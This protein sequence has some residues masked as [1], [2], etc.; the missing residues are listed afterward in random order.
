[1][2]STVKKIMVVFTV[3]CMLFA[4]LPVQAASPVISK[5]A[6]TLTIGKSTTL[7]VKNAKGKIKWKSSNSKIASVSKRGKVTGKKTGK[8]KITAIVNKRHYRCIVTVKATRKV[9]KVTN[10]K[11][12]KKNITLKAGKAYTLKASVSPSKASNKALAWK[13]SN[14]S[15][16]SVNSKGV[17]SAKKAGTVTITATAKDGSKKKASCKVTVKK[18][19]KSASDK[20]VSKIIVS[21]KKS[22]NINGTLQLNVSVQ[23]SGL[24]KT[25][26]WKSDN[27]KIATVSSTGLVK[28]VSAGT[29]KITVTTNDK[30]KDSIS[31]YITV[32]QPQN[33][34]TP[35]PVQKTI[36]GIEAVCGITEAS[37]IDD[38]KNH[39]T[40]YENY[41]DGTKAEVKGYS[42]KA[43]STPDSYKCTVTKTGTNFSTVIN[44]KKKGTSSSEKTLTGITAECT[45]KE[46]SSFDELIDNLVV[47]AHYSDGSTAEL[48]SYRVTSSVGGADGYGANI[49][50]MDGKFKTSVSAKTKISSVT[51]EN[52][53]ASCK[54]SEVESGYT[55]KTSD[56]DVKGVYSDGSKKNIGFKVDISYSNGAY[57]AII[58]AEN[59]SVTL[60]IPVKKS[61]TPEV[62]GMT[63]SLNPSYVYVGEN[64]ANGQLKVT[65]KYSDGSQ[66]EVTDY[67]CDFKPQSSAG[68][69]TFNVTWGT[70]KKAISIT[71]KEKTAP[72]PT[73]TGLDAKYNSSYVYAGDPFDASKIILTGTY[74]DG[75]TKQITD[76]TYDFTPATDHLGK[77]TLI[78]HYAG[79][80]MTIRITSIV[81]TEPKSVEFKFMNVP[82][83]VGENIDKSNI[84][85]TATDYAGTV[86]NP[87]DFTID[88]SPKTEAGTYPFTV[89]YKGFSETFNVTVK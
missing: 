89:S 83:G 46:V 52:I 65:A 57:K 74:S 43:E 48:K 30:W 26:T 73:L 37:S 33:T 64:L 67:A 56:F 66:K 14:K 50:T 19:S 9:T 61:S 5:K 18:A 12:N 24:S 25:F 77:A 22:V 62:T 55:F 82:I 59:H 29:V 39:M 54:Y 78:I 75:S 69:Y 85:I 42:V 49:E 86:T 34:P 47:T 88:F 87:T 44:V 20:R 72:T 81:K 21:S 16:A 84:T 51:L 15:I 23:P 7:K 79:Q 35:E 53:E 80:N 10:V 40:V 11:L 1:M 27:T 13:S 32:N 4:S 38:I 17:V 41:S 28:G 76:Y 6:I 2:R 58:T 68:T 3:F 45:L 31:V 63:Y 70:F 36:T 60:T 8:A 71:V